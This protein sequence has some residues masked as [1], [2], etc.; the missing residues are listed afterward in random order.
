MT[1]SAT[2]QL[3]ALPGANDPWQLRLHY[4][5]DLV[6][7]LEVYLSKLS[8][9][10][11]LDLSLQIRKIQSLN[12]SLQFSPL[13]FAL[14]I[15]LKESYAKKEIEPLLDA[16]QSLNRLSLD[17]AY[18]PHLCYQSILTEHWEAPFIQE[19]RN[20]TPRDEE[21]NILGER[22]QMF[23]LINARADDFPPLPLKEAEE[24]F[25]KLD[26]ALYEEY[27][28]YVSRVKLFSSTTITSSSSPRFFGCIYIRLPQVDENPLFFYLEYLVHEVSHL[29]LFVMMSEDP[30][31]L[32]APHEVFD[33]PLR[34]DKRP[35]MGIYHATFVLARLV[36]IFRKY[37]EKYPENNS[38]KKIFEAQDSLFKEGVNLV[39]AHAKLSPVGAHVFQSMMACAYE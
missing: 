30:M 38:A 25:K 9:A 34:P 1:L 2:Q 35:M 27:E 13:I 6:R 14:Y 10:L 17:E 11:K 3:S 18:A 7:S 22:G 12:S 23:P 24:L 36:R 5:E 20:S 31:V 15:S 28:A 37:V 33:S 21:G 19:L 16:V 26:P 4:Q 29:H 32:N 39:K 8:Q